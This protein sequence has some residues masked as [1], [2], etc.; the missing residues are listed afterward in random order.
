[1]FTKT[2]RTECCLM[3]LLFQVGGDL[4]FILEIKSLILSVGLT[5]ALKS[6]Q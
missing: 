2:R 4:T 3:E 1:M 5:E 6:F